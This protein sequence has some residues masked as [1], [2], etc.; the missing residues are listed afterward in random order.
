MH[1]VTQKNVNQ[2]LEFI[3]MNSRMTETNNVRGDRVDNDG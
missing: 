2:F 3:R 1:S